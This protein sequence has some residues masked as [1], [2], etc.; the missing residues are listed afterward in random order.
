VVGAARWVLY[1]PGCQSLKAKRKVVR[2]LRDRLRSRYD[3]SAAETDFQ[4]LWQKAE[5]SA[6]LVTSD[7]T[8]AESILSKLDRQVASDP[9]AQVIE[10]ENVFY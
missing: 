3:V 2:S 6:V 5:L 10:S 9:R 1:L 8:L 7:R 4:E